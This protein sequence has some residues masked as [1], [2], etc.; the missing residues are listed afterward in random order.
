MKNIS[1]MITG[2]IFP[3]ASDCN[4]T[5]YV[6]ESFGCLSLLHTKNLSQSYQGF[7]LLNVEIDISI[8]IS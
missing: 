7:F 5:Y 2:D 3:H 8:K 4:H 1:S 6:L